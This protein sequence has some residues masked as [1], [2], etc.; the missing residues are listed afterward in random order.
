[1]SEANFIIR[2]RDR[3]KEAFASVEGRMSKL[4]GGM[5]G[6][7]MGN[8]AGALGVA[9]LVAYG[10]AA[11]STGDQVDNLAGQL[12]LGLESVQ[13]MSVLMKEAGMSAEMLQTTMT[14]LTNKQM[15]ALS[16]NKAAVA[17]FERL[18]ISMDALRKMSP[19]QALEA[20]T[21]AMY[22]N[23]GNA[24]A[25]AAATDILGARSTKLQGVLLQLGSK[26]FADLNAD[27]LKS[28]Q[29]ME[30]DM[31]RA[32]DRMEQGLTRA[33]TKVGNAVKTK[34]L[35]AISYAWVGLG[36]V[37]MGDE[38]AANEYE[39]I[40]GDGPDRD[41]LTPEQLAARNE[42]AAMAGA[43]TAFAEEIEKIKEESRKMDDARIAMLEDQMAA[44]EKMRTDMEAMQYTDAAN[45][46]KS[47]Q[48][49]L[50]ENRQKKADEE[51]NA[52]LKAIRDEIKLIQTTRIGA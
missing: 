45:L 46:Q 44:T 32:G 29:I 51:R 48:M 2:A 13:S 28:G 37:F 9:G 23:Q 35:E 50:E 26:G 14:S 25:A 10:K 19:E 31:I 52:L 36:S 3:S 49:T 40:Y 43:R 12:N 4:M 34:F 21:R 41:E 39:N 15:E 16:G 17:Q 11:I 8:I 22:Q 33:F 1:M 5:R 7:G 20:V 47:A 42:E 38:W 27:M 30:K 18:G 24:S 6:L